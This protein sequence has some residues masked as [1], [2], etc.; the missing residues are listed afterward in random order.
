MDGGELSSMDI[1]FLVRELKER[2]AGGFFRK[3]YQY[4][5]KQF[6]FEVY[7]SAHGN[8]LLYADNKRMFIASEKEDAPGEP[9]SFCMLLRKHLSSRPI[10]DVRQHGFDRVVEIETDEN[11]IIFE[12]V[13]PG[14]IVLCDRMYN[15]IMPLELQRWKHREVKSGESYLFPPSQAEVQK[16]EIWDFFQTVSG[17]DRNVCFVL[18]GM[19]L[20]DSY[21]RE[22][23]ARAQL[24]HDK[25]ASSVT[26]DEATTLFN[27]VKAM[28]SAPPEPCIYG[29]AVSVFPLQTK[30]GSCRLASGLSEALDTYFSKTVEEE[31]QKVADDAVK[32]EEE[33]I[34]RIETA[35]EEALEQLSEKKV[36]KSSGAQA[37]YRHY[38]IISNV[39]TGIKSAR[40]SGMPWEQIKSRIAA[41][42][43]REARAVKEIREDEGK[44]ILSIDNSDVEIDMR[45]SPEEN[46]GLLFDTAK[47]IQKKIERIESL[48]KPEPKPMDKL[49]EEVQYNLTGKKLKE[50]KPRKPRKKKIAEG[51]SPTTESIKQTE[52]IPA[53]SAASPAIPQTPAEKMQA[54][55]ASITPPPAPKPQPPK[56]R[57]PRVPRAT[58]GRKWYETYRW[59]ISSEGNVVVGGKNA[60]Q[61][62]S[63]IKSRFKEGDAAFHADIHGAAFVIAKA[64]QSGG[65]GQLTVKEAAEFAAA[66]SKAWSS[67]F[68]EVDVNQFASGS[69]SKTS[70]DG[71]KLPRG[72]F[73][74]SATEGTQEK[75]DVRLSI[76]VAVADVGGVCEAKVLAGPL[77][78]VRK[79]CR[80][81]ATIQPG[82]VDCNELA[83]KVKNA[84]LAKCMPEHRRPIEALPLEEFSR[85]VP[86]GAGSLVG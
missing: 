61:N 69:L 35:R 6:V 10:K 22:A 68:T 53:G 12:F 66:Y 64:D 29:D 30:L 3:V 43:S 86:G 1:G 42:Q 23:C 2:L 14:N 7:S 75:V 9:P 39:L 57:K 13:P 38:D 28:L 16:L 26:V 50:Q 56:A 73:H 20:G 17:S 40:D 15:I 44:I 52:S 36:E 60:L 18:A 47:R 54:A 70:P 31:R 33:R 32:L 11:I 51:V 84:I 34:E 78:P 85:H 41:S 27:E 21:A 49:V 63:L 24:R 25:P 76:G 74:A 81:F 37:I 19:G 8:Q 77:M 5:R 65:V 45:K 83:Q 55:I 67:G 59:F 71:A 80:Y 58:K 46:A 48:P 79:S 72:S 82:A 62:D 4:G